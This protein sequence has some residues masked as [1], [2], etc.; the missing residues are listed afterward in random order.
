M[1]RITTVLI[2]IFLY[3]ATTMAEN[4][5]SP[6]DL[7]SLRCMEYFS[8]EDCEEYRKSALETGCI[9]QEELDLIISYE[10]CPLCN[11]KN[12]YIGWCPQKRSE[13]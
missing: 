11:R 10:G 1:L 7:Q 4:R 8:K 6:P 13:L 3:S 2:S 9:S 5:I 12:E